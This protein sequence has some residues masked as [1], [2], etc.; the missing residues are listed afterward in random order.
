MVV[1]TR[2]LVNAFVA[3]A[4]VGQNDNQCVLPSGCLAQVVDKTA[5]TLVQVVEGMIHLIVQYLCG[6]VPWFMTG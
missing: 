3:I 6:D 2:A 1:E 5:D 4:V